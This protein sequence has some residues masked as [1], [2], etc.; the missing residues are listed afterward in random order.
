VQQKL[1]E[2][3]TLQALRELRAAAQGLAVQHLDELIE[4]LAQEAANQ[5]FTGICEDFDDGGDLEEA[6]W[7]LSAA[8]YPNED[9]TKYREMIDS[10]GREVAGRCSS[11]LGKSER[12]QILSDFLGREMRLRGND[13]DYYA[14]ENSILPRVLDTRL[15]IPISLTLIYILVGRRAGV[16]VDGVGLPGHFLARHEDI[17]F[18]PFHGGRRV[19]LEECAA[20]ME[21]QNLVL[22]P[23]HLIATTARQVLVRMLTNLYFILEQ[24][25]PPMAAQVDAWNDLLRG[26]G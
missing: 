1:A 8:F 2:S 24:T 7:A 4:E 25:D 15:G 22:T 21:K 23:Q 12:V 19:G 18:D 20:L 16:Q 11:A 5:R 10:W 3:H 6:T 9:F 13:G 17:F 26:N 14:V